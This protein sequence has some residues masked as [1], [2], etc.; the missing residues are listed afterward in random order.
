VRGEGDNVEGGRTAS[1]RKEKKSREEE[2][3]KR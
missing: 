3:E 1:D 2:A